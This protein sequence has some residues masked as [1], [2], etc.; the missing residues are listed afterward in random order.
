M[1]ERHSASLAWV[2]ILAV[3]VGGYFLGTA[4]APD[5]HDA[6]SARADSAAVALAATHPLGIASGKPEGIVSG[7]AHGRRLGTSQGGKAGTGAATRKL[8]TRQLPIRAASATTEA[9]AQDVTGGSLPGSG[10]VLVVGDSLEVAIAPY[11]GRYLPSI[12]YSTHAKV[13]YSSPEI[14]GL[15]QESYDP[16]QSVVV[17]DAGTNDDPGSPEILGSQLRAV[18]DTIGNR[19]MV[20][21]TV[22]GPTVNGVGS[23]GLNRVIRDF[24]ASRPGTQVPDWANAA[25]THPEMI[26][27][28]GIHPT[29]AGAD[30]RAK[31]VA[32]G[33]RGCLGV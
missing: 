25:A 19:C 10:S 12:R 28:D 29:P 4:S 26:S 1:T 6:T 33:I 14:F 16:S 3:T 32:E 5:S 21:P 24:A 11:L 20:V 15:F 22:H 31:L 23:Q 30:L 17:F 18:G 13:G 7:Y 8:R 9:E 2:L 27:G